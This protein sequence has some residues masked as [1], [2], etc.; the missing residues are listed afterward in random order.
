M[1]CTPAFFIGAVVGMAIGAVVALLFAPSSGEELRIRIGQEA[2]AERE[3][4]LAGYDKAKHQAQ[5]RIEKMQHHQ[6]DEDA[7][8]G[9]SDQNGTAVLEG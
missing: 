4:A 7:P 5:E 6:Q 1:K 8:D 9:V 2:K 3:K